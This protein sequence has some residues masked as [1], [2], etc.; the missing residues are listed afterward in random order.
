MRSSRHITPPEE[1]QWECDI[2]ARGIVATLCTASDVR[3]QAVDEDQ[4]NTQVKEGVTTQQPAEDA[5]ARLAARLTQLLHTPG[6]SDKDRKLVER[7]LRRLRAAIGGKVDH[8]SD[9]PF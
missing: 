4:N 3:L 5:N 2:P 6:I 1:L 7:N 9:N 8:Q